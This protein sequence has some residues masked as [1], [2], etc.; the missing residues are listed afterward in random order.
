MICTSNKSCFDF[1]FL[2]LPRYCIVSHIS[3]SLPLQPNFYRLIQNDSHL[4]AMLGTLQRG[5]LA[6]TAHCATFAVSTP[7]TTC[8]WRSVAEVTELLPP[9]PLL[10]PSPLPFLFFL[11][12]PPPS[13]APSPVFCYF[14]VWGGP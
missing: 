7:K 14:C 11:P 5:V 8:C 13:P 2:F 9:G 10:N 3:C 6:P 1:V 4:V 12:P